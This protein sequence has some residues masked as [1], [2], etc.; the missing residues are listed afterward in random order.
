MLEVQ[1]FETNPVDLLDSWRDDMLRSFRPCWNDIPELLVL[2]DGDTVTDSVDLGRNR[3]QCMDRTCKRRR[4]ENV[5]RVIVSDVETRDR[6]AERSRI[7]NHL[8][9]VRERV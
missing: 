5:V 1:E 9:R 8:A 6:F 4:A 2:L 7:G 3:G